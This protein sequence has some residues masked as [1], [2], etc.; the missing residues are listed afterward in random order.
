[1]HVIF[2]MTLHVLCEKFPSVLCSF[3]RLFCCRMAYARSGKQNTINVCDKL[4]GLAKVTYLIR[5]F[6]FA[7]TDFNAEL[8]PKLGFISYIGPLY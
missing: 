4:Q 3:S 1:M 8:P 7:Q 5:F 2:F 6:W